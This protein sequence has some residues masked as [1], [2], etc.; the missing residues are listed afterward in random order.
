MNLL[1]ASVSSSRVRS[2]MVMKV[3]SKR[4]RLANDFRNYNTVLLQVAV[5]LPLSRYSTIK[6]AGINLFVKVHFVCM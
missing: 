1:E 4:S 6:C 5:V 3:R 2:T